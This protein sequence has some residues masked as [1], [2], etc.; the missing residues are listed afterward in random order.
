MKRIQ[1][2]IT[3]TYVLVAAAVIA[4]V[5]ILSSARIEPYFRSQLRDHLV[6]QSD[7]L[8][9]LLE[10]EPKASR[11]RVNA[12]VKRFAAMAGVRVTLIDTA[13]LVLADSDVPLE[14]LASLEN[15]LHR[16]EVQEALAKGVGSSSRHSA[17]VG[18]DLLYVVRRVEPSNSSGYLQQME[19]IRLSRDLNDVQRSIGEIRFCIFIAGLVVLLVIA[20]VSTLIS[21][22]ISKPMEEISRRVE[23]IR[24]GNFEQH[25]EIRSND[26]IGQVARAVNELVD[27]LQ[28]DIVELRKLQ[29][30]RS[31]FLGNVSHELRTPI[32]A[33][34]GHLET[35]LSG[36]LEDSRVN[37]DFLQKA[38]QHTLRLNALL[39][40]L[41]DISR[42]ESKEMN[43]SFR[44]FRLGDLLELILAEKQPAAG[45]KEIF[46]ELKPR[47]DSGEEVIG[48]KDRIRQVMDN[49]IDNAI[50]YTNPGGRVDVEYEIHDRSVTVSVSDTGCGIPKEHISRIFERFYRVDRDRSRELGGTGLGLAIVKHI[51]EAHGSNV[52]VSSEV[53]K[54]SRFSFVLKR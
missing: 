7:V 23:E 22:R 11:V 9:F 31:E 18:R 6:S 38:Y 26:E 25:I 46:L 24:S 21:R 1:S 36:A 16:P 44:Y 5:G 2:K 29:R 17:T 49:L 14:D 27:K 51:I 40:D 28:S 53:G 47:D 8:R 15:H 43:M 32:F 19:F 50:K 10:E 35:L 54:G 37:R 30:V 41:I 39:E 4:A 52:N 20:G 13:G 33:I 48:D 3:L 12:V 34:Q 42:I 45:Q